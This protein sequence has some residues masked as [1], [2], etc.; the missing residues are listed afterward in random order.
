MSHV[1][2]FTVSYGWFKSLV[3]AMSG[4]KACSEFIAWGFWR[5]MIQ[6]SALWQ[7]LVTV[8]GA[9]YEGMGGLQLS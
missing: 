5:R 7:L 3:S 8:L 9:G 6:N 2:L 1:E 4:L